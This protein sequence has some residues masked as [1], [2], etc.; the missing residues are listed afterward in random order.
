MK[1][2]IEATD[3]ITRLDGVECR[4]WRGKTEKGTKCLVFIHRITPEINEDKA[5]FASELNER[6]P[7]GF[8]ID[9]RHLL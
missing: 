7:P 9:L 4:L 3:K 6:L 2:E 1:L 8:Y 5:E